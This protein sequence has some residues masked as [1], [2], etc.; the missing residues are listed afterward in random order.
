MAD[1]AKA[2]RMRQ[3]SIYFQEVQNAQDR[4]YVQIRTRRAEHRNHKKQ[5]LG[6]IPYMYIPAVILLFLGFIALFLGIFRAVSTD[7]FFKKHK[8]VTIVT[9]VSFAVSG[10]ILM[11]VTEGLKHR[12]NTK[13][14]FVPRFEVE[15]IAMAKRRAN[16]VQIPC[17]HQERLLR[18]Y[19][20][21]DQKQPTKDQIVQAYT[22]NCPALESLVVIKTKTIGIQTDETPF[23]KYLNDMFQKNSFRRKNVIMHVDSTSGVSSSSSHG[24]MSSEFDE[25]S[26]LL[27]H[28][29]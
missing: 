22:D 9:G 19:D 6:R 18:I 8:T 20:E 3:F 11:L 10:I 5:M 26:L 29:K 28:K 1:P 7:S 17:I 25:E 4:H 24:C 15:Q 14:N 21:N 16:I 12:K 13:L 23:L 27:K 2:E